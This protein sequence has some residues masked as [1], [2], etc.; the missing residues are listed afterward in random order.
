MDDNNALALWALG[1]CAFYMVVLCIAAHLG[2]I[3]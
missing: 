1:L 2:A 3:V